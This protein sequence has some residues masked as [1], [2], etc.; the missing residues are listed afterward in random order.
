M[1]LFV[2]E[3]QLFQIISSSILSNICPL[4]HIVCINASGCLC[5]LRSMS[6]DNGLHINIVRICVIGCLCMFPLTYSDIDQLDFDSWEGNEQI[7]ISVC[8]FVID[9]F[10]IAAWLIVMVNL[11]Y[12]MN[13]SI[14]NEI[15]LK[16]MI[17]CLRLIQWNLVVFETK[18]TNPHT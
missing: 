13:N 6:I 12:S 9:L 11:F 7:L 18:K 14:M 15:I 10:V 3:L 1:K 8:G 17:F 5:I 2:F 4:P 16:K